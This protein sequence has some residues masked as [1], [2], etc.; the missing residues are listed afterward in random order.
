MSSSVRT[1]TAPSFGS[2]RGSGGG[3]K[4]GRD[5]DDGRDPNRPVKKPKPLDH[6]GLVDLGP[7]GPLR[8]MILAMMK[9][10][11]LGTVPSGGLLTRGGQPKTLPERTDCVHRWLSGH[12]HASQ[13]LVAAKYTELAEAFVHM[14]RAIAAA[15]LFDQLVSMLVEVLTNLAIA[16]QAEGDDD[17]D[18][19]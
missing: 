9:V 15:G 4:R 12:L 18:G 8:A 13:G 16:A 5:G 6:F 7:D 19:D 2:G 1:V 10:G 17:S 14:V 3:G 11:N